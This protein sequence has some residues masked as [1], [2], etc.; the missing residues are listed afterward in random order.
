MPLSFKKEMEWSVLYKLRVSKQC[1]I[2]DGECFS[3]EQLLTS[4]KHIWLSSQV[5]DLDHNDFWFIT[6]ALSWVEL[7][8]LLDNVFL[9]QIMNS[10]NNTGRHDCSCCFLLI[11]VEAAKLAVLWKSDEMCFMGNSSVL[12][13]PETLT[14]V[15]KYFL[16]WKHSPL[17]VPSTRN[18]RFMSSGFNHWCFSQAKHS[19]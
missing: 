3:D 13:C 7:K 2:H 14:I 17:D 9:M 18:V 8:V 11:S 10:N 5:S 4:G 19:C 16:L 6:E 15:K 12:G 1:T